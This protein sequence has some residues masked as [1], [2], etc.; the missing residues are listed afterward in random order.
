MSPRVYVT[1]RGRTG[2]SFGV[3]G[4]IFYL[5]A[6]LIYVT[7]AA[8]VIVVM[9]VVRLC[10]AGGQAYQRKRRARVEAH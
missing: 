2:V 6:M 5:F 10:V 1:S 8:C 9:V 7:I 4:F 3:I